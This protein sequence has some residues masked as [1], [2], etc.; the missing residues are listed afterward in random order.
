[1]APETITANK[2]ITVTGATR[3]EVKQQLDALCAQGKEKGLDP[4]GGFIHYTMG[5]PGIP[6][7]FEATI[8]FLKK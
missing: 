6:D 4:Q 2:P 7:K 5:V 1:M 3:A 8:T